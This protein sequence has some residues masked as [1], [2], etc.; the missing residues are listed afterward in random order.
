MLLK[1]KKTKT[2]YIIVTGGVLSG[3]GKGT[4]T[5]CIGKVLKEQGFNI[6][7]I[8]IDPY[9]NVDAG[10]MSPTEH[11]EVYV[12]FDGGETDQDLGN[13]ERFL[14]KEF[15]KMN[16][17]T[18]GQVYLSVINHERNLEYKGECVSVIPHVPDEIK[19]RIRTSSKF[20]D[21]DF[22]LIE[23][24]GTTGDYEN[25]LFLEALREMKLEKEECLFMHVVYLPIPGNL[26]HRES[27]PDI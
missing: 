21:A 15:S 13:Y 14:D 6:N 22:T 4:I 8:K 20:H 27:C 3:V 7:V 11:G 23:V 12:T 17:I 19:K 5:S 2:K 1:N 9:L 10:T 24:G 26:Y 18:S 16:S 25:I